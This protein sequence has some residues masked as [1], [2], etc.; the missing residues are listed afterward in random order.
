MLHRFRSCSRLTLSRFRS[1]FR[2]SWK[3]TK[4][5]GRI[6]YTVADE[7]GFIPS[8]FNFRES[9]RDQRTV[10]WLVE[11]ERAHRAPHARMH[12]T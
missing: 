3:K 6:R 1:R 2:F 4:T 12:G 11:L 9:E 8:I 5:D 7:T 10:T